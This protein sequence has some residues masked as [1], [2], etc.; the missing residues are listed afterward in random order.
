MSEQFY[1][2]PAEAIGFAKQSVLTGKEKADILFSELGGNV[3]GGMLKYFSTQELR[4]IRKSLKRLRG[5]SRANEIKTLEE[6]NRFGFARKILKLSPALL[7]REEYAKLHEN[8]GNKQM[9]RNLAKN[10]DAV[11]N[12][13]SVWLKEDK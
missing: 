8:D 13:I 10:A 3:T 4:T 12:V 11:A 5:Y 1:T 6:A 2:Q 9:L 7:N